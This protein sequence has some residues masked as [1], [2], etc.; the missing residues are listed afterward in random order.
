MARRILPF[1]LVLAALAAPALAGEG[2]WKFVIMS[3]SQGQ[4]AD[5]TDGVSVQTLSAV[6]THVLS[7]NK[8]ELIVFTGDL[9]QGAGTAEGLESQLTTFRKTMEP[10]YA[11]KIP[12]Y[13]LRGSHDTGDNNLRP[14]ANEVWN[15][16][17]AGPYAMP[18]NGPE[19]EKGLT[20]SLSH[21]NALLV[22]LDGY[23]TMGTSDLTLNLPWLKTQL[24][25]N[26]LPHVFAFSHTQVKKVEHTASLDAVPAVRNEFVQMLRAAGARA[27]FCG[28][29]HCSNHT[30][31]NDTKAD[32]ADK[33]PDDD[34]HQFIVPACSQKFY[35]WRRQAYDGHAI[36]GLKPFK[37]H[38]AER[39]NGYVTVDVDGPKVTVTSILRGRD[40]SFA[41]AATF[42]YTLAPA[43]PASTPAA[44]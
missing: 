33:S 2:A 8:P 11:A 26:R 13:A 27:Y 12:V 42:T 37:V 32:P 30:R 44:K 4:G 5:F 38:H 22:G 18:A 6:L 10:A 39:R 25:A 40:G 17:F 41:P 29:M 23:K 31:F 16:V 19:G 7:A 21:R 43:V 36:P 14:F 1:L 24:A 3:D 15:K 20:W 9:V 28:H 34:F 35:N